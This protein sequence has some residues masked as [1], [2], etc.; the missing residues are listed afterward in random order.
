MVVYESKRKPITG[1]AV[2]YF[3][4]REKRCVSSIVLLLL[5]VVLLM[6]VLQP[7][8]GFSKE[9]LKNYS[10]HASPLSKI[11]Q[12]SESFS[13]N[14][15]TLATKESDNFFTDI[16]DDHWSMLKQIAKSVQPNT[17]GDPLKSP[18]TPGT[19]FQMHYE[20]EFSCQF[21]AR[22]GLKGDGGKWVCDP[23][24][25][26]RDSGKCLVYSVGS[27]GEAN[28]EA[29]ILRDISKE[30][31]IHVFDFGDYKDTVAEQTGNSRNVH[32]HKWGISDKTHGSFKTL[33]D[34]VKLLG[35]ESR[36]I[37][38]FKIDC[39]GCEFDT[40][41]SWLDAP[42]KLRQILL[43]VHPNLSSLLRPSVKLPDTVNMFNSLHEK[44]YVI[45]HKEPNIM[46]SFPRGH[47]VEYNFLLLSPKFWED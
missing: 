38:I 30:C 10:F 43:E 47:C 29:A 26:S 23:H 8:N 2:I 27:N 11:Q 5:T 25:I 24:R 31:E 9:E 18:S 42:V 15:L 41:S 3:L 45:T 16:P 34:T 40:Y 39:E 44:G 6:N 20:P 12:N 35:H 46:Y 14:S 13:S 22:I 28:F 17:R 33:E 19:W 7:K 1:R 37:D 21:E 4:G 32:Y 36:T